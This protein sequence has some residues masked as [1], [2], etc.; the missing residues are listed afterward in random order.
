[1]R[2]C[3]HHFLATPLTQ[4]VNIGA[5]DEQHRLEDTAVQHL[6][7]IIA[8]LDVFRIVELREPGELLDRVQERM[9]ERQPIELRVA[10]EKTRLSI[11][12]T[13]HCAVEQAMRLV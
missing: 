10:N 5:Q 2:L 3:P 7:E 8:R 11:R 12:T 1:M 6:F 9:C 4:V 13:A